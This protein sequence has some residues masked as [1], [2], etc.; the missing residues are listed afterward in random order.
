MGRTNEKIIVLP[1]PPT[2]GNHQHIQ[3]RNGRRFLRKDVVMWRDEVSACC[4]GTSYL[5][6]KPLGVEM[7]VYMPDNRRRD[8]G[9]VEK[10]VSDALQQSSTILNDELLHEIH[11]YRA[12]VDRD[13]PR[14]EVTLWEL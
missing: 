14:V 3:A 8:I 11:L 6:Y 7:R 12:G 9:N 13:A 4:S 1:F 5:S 2:T 10:L